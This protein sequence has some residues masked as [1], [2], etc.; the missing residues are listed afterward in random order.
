MHAP[1]RGRARA[2][3]LL[4]VWCVHANARV[5]HRATQLI[6]L[7]DGDGGGQG[8]ERACLAPSKQGESALAREMIRRHSQTR[9]VV[10][11]QPPL[12]L[13]LLDGVH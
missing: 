13:L 1:K 12:V 5:H 11:S 2:K 3:T 4:C 8:R 10:N 7:G 6:N 9:R